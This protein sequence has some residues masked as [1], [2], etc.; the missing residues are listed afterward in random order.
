MFVYFLLLLFLMVLLFHDKD[1]Y[2]LNEQL[3]LIFNFFLLVVILYIN[4]KI[5]KLTNDQEGNNGSI[6]NSICT[7]LIFIGFGS[8]L[9]YTLPNYRAIA[10]N[11]YDLKSHALPLVA[12]STILVWSGYI[13]INTKYI[14]QKMPIA[15][16]PAI[17]TYYLIKNIAGIFWFFYT[18]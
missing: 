14:I 11:F 6:R 3:I 7:L 13:G 5:L 15:I 17:T 1:R 10:L 18:S 9:F 2:Y 16:L 12:F 4:Y 8:L